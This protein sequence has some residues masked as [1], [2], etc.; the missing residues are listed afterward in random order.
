MSPKLALALP[1]RPICVAAAFGLGL[2]ALRA[3]QPTTKTVDDNRLQGIRAEEPAKQAPEEFE[4]ALLI[5][6]LGSPTFGERER[7]EKEL[8]SI[9]FP[10]LP[11]LQRAITFP[12]KEM[13]RRAQRAIAKINPVASQG[14][15]LPIAGLRHKKHLDELIELLGSPKFNE[16]EQ[17]EKVLV[18]LGSVA[19]PKLEIAL[20]SPDKEVARRAK[21]AIAEIE[22]LR[23]YAVSLAK[24]RLPQLRELEDPNPYVRLR[25]LHDLMHLEPL[26]QEAMP[27]FSKGL[28]DPDDEVR[29][30]GLTGYTRL[31]PRRAALD[32]RR[33]VM[34]DEKESPKVRQGAILGLRRFKAEAEELIPDLLRL[35]HANDPKPRLAAAS[36]LGPLG[37]GHAEVVPALLD[38]LNDPHETVRGNAAFSLGELR[39]EPQQ[40]VPAIHRLL[41]REMQRR[42]KDT[43]EL[44]SILGG[45]ILFGPEAKESI[46]TVFAIAKD[47][48]VDRMIRFQAL[49][50]LGEMGPSANESL[51]QLTIVGDPEIAFFAKGALERKAR[52]AL[53]QKNP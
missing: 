29:S 25:A 49:T 36:V 52:A 20:K 40:C 28:D 31:I 22:R 34:W 19:L 46:P 42:E 26:P 14:V 9:G 33:A 21:N 53:K 45:L 41:Q 15:G 32:K 13:A 3:D 18:A 8:V 24:G 16:R 17:A 2:A 4:I 47:V 5:Q 51:R 39:Q 38:A 44:T 10:A 27:L 50:C 11:M 37:K 12:D 48:K 43:H 30:A 23:S 7:A 35:L 1:W 6:Q